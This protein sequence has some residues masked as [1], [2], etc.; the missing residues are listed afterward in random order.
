MNPISSYFHKNASTSQGK[1]QDGSDETLHP[2][3]FF[4]IQLTQKKNH[5]IT[6]RGEKK[7][8]QN[9]QPCSVT[10]NVPSIW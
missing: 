4:Y 1:S 10:F 3:P 8:L 2:S 7:E 5:K 6:L 9:K